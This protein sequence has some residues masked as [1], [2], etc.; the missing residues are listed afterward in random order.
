MKKPGIILLLAAVLSACGAAG[1]AEAAAQNRN[2]PVLQEKAGKGTAGIFTKSDFCRIRNRIEVKKKRKYPEVVF[3]GR[4]GK[5]DADDVSYT[6]YRTGKGTCVLKIYGTGRMA[7]YLEPE[8]FYSDG[9]TYAA[10]PLDLYYRFRRPWDGGGDSKRY[11]EAKDQCIKIEIGEGITSIGEGA[12]TY[13]QNPALEVSLPSTLTEIGGYAFALSVVKEIDIPNRVELIGECAFANSSLKHIVLPDSL[14]KLGDGVFRNTESLQKVDN[15]NDKVKV[16]DD[17]AFSNTGIESMEIPDSVETVGDMAFM[18]CR[19]LKTITMGRN[20]KD[21]VLGYSFF[22]GCTSLKKVEIPESVKEID[23][24]AFR[25]CTSLETVVIP[26][27]VVRIGWYAFLGCKSLA[28]L[29][30]PDSVTE[31]K[32]MAFSGSGL[33]T[34]TLPDGVE[35]LS[36]RVF[37]NC[38]KLAIVRLGKGI[39]TIRKTAFSG[40]KSLQ[41]IQVPKKQYKQYKKLLKKPLA[42]HKKVKIVKY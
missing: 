29:T 23:D 39:K 38:E 1:T 26:D 31:I 33:R 18:G 17:A 30:I 35:A 41:E 6:M 2:Q 15:W 37:D 10:Q 9:E 5:S 28:D 27:G 7:D 16:I 34:V 36:Y 32:R 24:E 11:S 8:D 22:N 19:R 25:D 20:Q 12:F 42:K 3:S 14:E 21:T 40:C 13:F 4:C